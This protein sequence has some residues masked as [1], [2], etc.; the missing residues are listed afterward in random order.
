MKTHWLRIVAIAFAVIVLILIALPFLINVNSFRPK[1]ESE[2]SSALGRKVTV[3]NLSLSIFSRTVEADNIVIA[4]DPAFSKSPF[5]TAQSLKIGIELMPLIFSRQ[6]KA[7]EIL[8]EQPQITWLRAANG[9]WNYSSLG[10]APANTA[11][12][13]KSA[14]SAPIVGKNKVE[15]PKSGESAPTSVSFG[16]LNINNG[17]LMVGRA[18]SSAKPRVYDNVNLAVTDFSPTSQFPFKLTA[19][20]P[21]GGGADIAGKAG[22]INAT[23]ASKTPFETTV[24]VNNMDIAAS[25]FI[26]P[27]TGLAGIANFDG[28]LTSTGSQAKAVGTFTGTKMKLAP[29]GSPGAKTVVIKHTVDVDLDNHSGTLTR[30][31]IAVGKAQAHLTGTFQ[32]GGEVLVVNMKLNAPGMPVEDLE[33]MLPSLGIVLPSGSQLKG[34]TLSANL[35]ITGPAD[36]LVIAGPVK[37]SDTSLAGFNLGSKMGALS[38]FAGKA[39]SNPDTSIRNFSVDAHYSPAGTQADNINLDV[40]A[41]GVITGAGTVSPE[42]ALSFKMLAN[43]SGGMVGGLSKVAAAGSGTSGVPFAIEGTTSDPKFVPEL[44]GVASSLATGAVKGVAGG[45]PTATAAPKKAVSGLLGVKK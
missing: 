10:V 13:T 26:N 44:G 33:A 2:A 27:A 36:K 22:P 32:T 19:T 14:A 24:K 16:K 45:V 37:L 40:P 25:G 41:I 11:D 20:L 18:N 8:L 5:L 31:D 39:V 23:D 34:G 28:T 42:G 30:G 7:T 6:V 38:A 4:D 29:R 21:G 12:A 15:G 43:L 35:A 17:K 3:G 1:I 9:A